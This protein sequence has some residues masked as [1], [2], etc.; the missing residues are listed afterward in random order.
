MRARTERGLRRLVVTGLVALSALAAAPAQ[1]DGRLHAHPVLSFTDPRV[2]ESSG[3][4]DAGRLLFT[5]NDSGDGP[6]VYAVD[7]RTGVTTAVTTYSRDD[8][9]DVE[10]IAPGR[11]G[12]LW[13]GDLGDNRGDR[14]EVDVYRLRPADRTGAVVSTRYRFRYPDGARDAET[15]LVDPRSG[16]LLV[17]S[18]SVF[19]GTVYRAPARLDPTGV[20]RL[21]P[22]A[23][24]E[25]LVT[26]GAFFP[27]GKHVVLR[28]YDSAS[29]YS[30]PDFA[31]VGTVRLPDQDQGEG[32]AV[33]GDG[34]VLLSSEGLRS[35]VLQVTLP[36]WMTRPAA[37]QSA[38]VPPTPS[39]RPRTADLDPP[40]TAGDWWRAAAVGAV[41]L[42]VGVA[43]A[44]L[45]RRTR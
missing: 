2:I 28:T 40:S 32:I 45:L 12:T 13:V 14:D 4:V 42:A 37:V 5:I 30:Y 9:T 31:L 19:G 27:D 24:V 34:R 44:R 17:V 29:T 35:T 6:Y 3:L 43:G 33:G 22:F 16:R 38:P 21:H 23:G 41:L 36:A 26:D 20:N 10:A 39:A 25:G 15:L 7:S 18:K 8:V 1:A 11:R